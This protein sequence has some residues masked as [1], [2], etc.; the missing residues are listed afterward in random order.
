MNLR[1]SLSAKIRLALVAGSLLMM[2]AGLASK[3][4]A[5]FSVKN[6]EVCLITGT[7]FADLKEAVKQY[8]KTANR[9]CTDL[10]SWTDTGTVDMTSEIRI[11]GEPV[12]DGEGVLISRLSTVD[13]T[14]DAAGLGDC[15]IKV[16]AG[17]KISLKRITITVDDR[18]TAVCDLAGTPLYDSLTADGHVTSQTAA[19]LDIAEI[20]PDV[21]IVGPGVKLDMG[22]C[23]KLRTG[24]RP[25]GTYSPKGTR[26]RFKYI[27]LALP[28]ASAPL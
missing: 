18:D 4:E 20:Q 3:A 7:N 9:L 16:E 11:T 17:S 14:L 6:S 10:I 28:S 8:N 23:I 2:T 15:P 5:G 27:P 12:N 24:A 19:Q 22:M 25:Q 26:C 21:T 13:L 1:K